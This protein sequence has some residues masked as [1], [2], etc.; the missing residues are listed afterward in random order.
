MEQT[1]A[2]LDQKYKQLQNNHDK[3]QKEMA[4]LRRK[5]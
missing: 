3:T 2:E 1:Y 4:V 5:F